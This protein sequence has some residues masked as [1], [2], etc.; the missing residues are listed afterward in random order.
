LRM[1]SESADILQRYR[2]IAA[3][4]RVDGV[5]LLEIQE[6]DSRVGLLQELRLPAVGVNAD[7]DGFPLPC[8]RQDHI[9]GIT[10][11][12]NYLAGVGHV[13]IAYVSGPEKFVHAR[14]RK[15]TWLAAMAALGLTPGSQVQGDFTYDGGRRAADSLLSLNI[16]PTAVICAN[17]LTAIGFMA[18]AEELGVSI[19]G[20]ISVAGFDGIQLGAYVRPTL[21]TVKTSPRDI[22]AEAAR[23]LLGVVEGREVSDVNVSPAELLLRDSSGRAP[24]TSS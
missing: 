6:D 22:G 7:V 9:A 11:L 12:I 5:F 2:Q 16:R 10:S 3:D 18:R 4:R 17:D 24:K 15:D 23:M 1:E 20:E 8:V 19:P 13:N 21:T 14:Q